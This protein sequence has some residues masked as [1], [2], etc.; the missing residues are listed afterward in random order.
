[1]ITGELVLIN[2]EFQ[3]DIQDL[4]FLPMSMANIELTT[5]TSGSTS[6]Y[7]W[8][9]PTSLGR[10]FTQT[11][12]NTNTYE[13][14]TPNSQLINTDNKDNDEVSNEVNDEFDDENTTNSLPN[15]QTHV[16]RRKR[17]KK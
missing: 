6:S 17:T 14:S 13:N 11:M 2:S 10:L 1:M 4:N 9:T 5:T 15:A 8:S 3:V 7:S 12:A 16:H